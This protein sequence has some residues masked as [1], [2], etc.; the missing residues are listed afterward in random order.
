MDDENMDT[1]PDRPT[2]PFAEPPGSVT[3]SRFVYD[4]ESGYIRD[5]AK[6]SCDDEHAWILDG[7]EGCAV[8]NSLAGRLAKMEDFIR[9]VRDN[10]DCD[11]DAHKYGTMCRACEAA[12]LSPNDKLRD[13]Q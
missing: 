3:G 1:N 12:R 9:S 4:P 11:A 13:G 2:Q 5:T 8:L 10:F 6:K 7:V